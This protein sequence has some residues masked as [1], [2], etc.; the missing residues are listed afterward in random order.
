MF[1]IH[2]SLSKKLLILEWNK[3]DN[4][5]CDS[6]CIACSQIRAICLSP[7]HVS[8]RLVSRSYHSIPSLSSSTVLSMIAALTRLYNYQ[9]LGPWS[10]LGV[11]SKKCPRQRITLGFPMRSIS[12]FPF[13]LI[14]QYCLLFWMYDVIF[15]FTH[16]FLY[17]QI[18]AAYTC[19]SD[20]S[21]NESAKTKE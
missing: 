1:V 8:Y 17:P 15:H 7:L 18:A 3:N 16:I 10:V 2:M 12:T 21:D 6:Y 13:L 19:S 9:R 5:Q 11:P 4:V 20:M 14:I